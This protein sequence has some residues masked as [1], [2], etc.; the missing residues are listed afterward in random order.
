MAHI[1]IKESDSVCFRD[2]LVWKYCLMIFA[3]SATNFYKFYLSDDDNPAN[4]QIIYDS[5]H[6]SKWQI[7]TLRRMIRFQNDIYNGSCGLY[8]FRLS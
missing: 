4:R 1:G 8:I 7:I 6:R 2:V 5:A 3:I